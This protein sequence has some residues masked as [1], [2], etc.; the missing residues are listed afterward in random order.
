MTIAMLQTARWT[1]IASV[2]P[3]TN[4]EETYVLREILHEALCRLSDEDGTCVVLRFVQGERYADIAELLGT[5]SEAVR[6][7]VA[8]GIVV[9]REA[10][11]KTDAGED[12]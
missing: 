4:P 5:T 1:S 3:A 12:S 6:K 10:I 7:R 9:M 8:R 11:Q 2:E